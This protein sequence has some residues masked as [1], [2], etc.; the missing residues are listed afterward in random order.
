[1]PLPPRSPAWGQPAASLLSLPRGLR[2]LVVLD[3]GAK[4]GKQYAPRLKIR[5]PDDAKADNA[6]KVDAL[7][8][9]KRLNQRVRI[10]PTDKA[11]VAGLT[12]AN[13]RQVY[14]RR[15]FADAKGILNGVRPAA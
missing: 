7:V 12:L 15:S 14:P 9:G 11:V 3:D 5:V 13:E 10:E 1:M 2:G 6:T 8:A 4:A